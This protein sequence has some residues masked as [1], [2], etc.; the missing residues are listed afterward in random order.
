L[1]LVVVVP[2]VAL[3]LAVFPRDGVDSLAVW[4]FAVVWPCALS[5]GVSLGA[6]PLSELLALLLGDA[7]LALAIADEKLALSLGSSV[8][9]CEEES[10]R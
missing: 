1:R 7:A 4:P 10:F 5:A 9:A 2:G 6:S 8:A 3:A